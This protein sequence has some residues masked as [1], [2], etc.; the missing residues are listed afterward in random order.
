[1]GN[2]NLPQSGAVG[3]KNSRDT[4][5]GANQLAEPDKDEAARKHDG[6]IGQARGPA[7]DVPER[8]SE[9]VDESR[10]QQ[11]QP[12]R[13]EQ[14]QRNATREQLHEVDTA[15]RENAAGAT[16]PRRSAGHANTGHSP[17]NAT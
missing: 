1:M 5:S 12:T 14:R 9:P 15:S 11:D 6:A 2:T 3:S 7:Q 13:R 10:G 17:S 16:D 4:L 8:I